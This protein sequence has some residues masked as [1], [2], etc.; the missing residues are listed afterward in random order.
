MNIFVYLIA[1]LVAQALRRQIIILMNRELG[2][3]GKKRSWL[4]R[5]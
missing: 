2:K 1:L 5:T 4:K 3:C